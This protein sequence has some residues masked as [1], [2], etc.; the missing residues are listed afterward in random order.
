MNKTLYIHIGHYKTGTTALQVFFE[1]SEGFLKKHGLSYPRVC[2]HNSKH[3]AFAFSILH[4]AGVE[5]LMYN[6][7]DSASPE[8]MWGELFDTVMSARVPNMLISSEEFMRMGQFPA[9]TNILSKILNSRPEGLTVKAIVY[10]RD[11]ASHL[12]SWYNQLIKMNFPV[13]NLN[14]AVDGDIED[15]HFNYRKALSPWIDILGQGNVIIRPYL[16]DR[17]N[18]GALHEDFFRILGIDLPRN[19]VSSEQDPNPR[20]DDRAIELVRLM[21]NLGLPRRTLTTIRN[22]ALSYLEAQDTLHHGEANGIEGARNQAIEGLDWLSTL[23]GC[24]VPIKEFSQNLPEPLPAQ[25][26]D[27]TLLLGFVFSE[28]IQL[29]QRV[30][31]AGLADLSA[32]IS[33]LEERLGNQENI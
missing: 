33:A 17:S 21:Q 6:Y 7:S 30:N 28:L 20:L 15:I 13:A 32:R 24:Q 3:S 5:K 8:A 29:R 31:N 14:A 4:A 1:R 27:S 10:L 19:L 9:A 2:Y 12:H 18:P 16:H 23:S 26:V 22:H 25:A 11:P